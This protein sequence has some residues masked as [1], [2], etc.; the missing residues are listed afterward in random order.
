MTV[1]LDLPH[2]KG[3]I[4]VQGVLEESAEEDVNH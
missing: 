3:R 4:H 2:L 1:K